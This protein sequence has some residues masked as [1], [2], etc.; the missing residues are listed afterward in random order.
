MLVFM[1]SQ[2]VCRTSSAEPPTNFAIPTN[3]QLILST[4]YSTQ[5]KFQV[6]LIYMSL[7]GSEF[8]DLGP[9]FASFADMGSMPTIPESTEVTAVAP[10]LVSAKTKKST[11]YLRWILGAWLY[12][13]LFGEELTSE[14]A[15]NTSNFNPVWTGIMLCFWAVISGVAVILSQNLL[16]M[17]LAVAFY[18]LTVLFMFFGP[19]IS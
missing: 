8:T 10:A 1:K 15:S 18:L 7:P 11:S 16:M 14:Y 5:N 17:G 9:N 3:K 6:C 19:T 4:T 2:M 13:M 12:G